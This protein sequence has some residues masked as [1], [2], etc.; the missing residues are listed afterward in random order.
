MDLSAIGMQAIPTERR[1]RSMET[2]FHWLSRD[3]GGPSCAERAESWPSMAMPRTSLSLSGRLDFRSVCKPS[4]IPFTNFATLSSQFAVMYSITRIFDYSSYSKLVVVVV[5]WWE[6]VMHE[7]MNNFLPS[8]RVLDRITAALLVTLMVII[9]V[10][11]RLSH[12]ITH[13]IIASTCSIQL[14]RE[15][16]L[17]Y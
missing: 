8:T 11:A 15:I 2:L 14:S 13:K 5:H 1:R 10:L 9:M 12:I 17:Y 3:Y 6:M 7:K 4:Q 16:L